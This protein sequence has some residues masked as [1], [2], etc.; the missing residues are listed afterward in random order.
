MSGIVRSL[1]NPPFECLNLLRLQRLVLFGRGHDFRRVS[2]N[3]PANQS[4]DIRLAGNYRWCTRISPFK[5][6]LTN[7]QSKPTLP[8]HVIATMTRRAMFSKDW[9]DIPLKINC[10]PL[11][12]RAIKQTDYRCNENKSRYRKAFHSRL[13]LGWQDRMLCHQ[14]A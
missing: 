2:R 11:S 10:L 9:L 4:T 1:V 13:N 14:F 12:D 8:S 3:D 5:S 7:I 6:D